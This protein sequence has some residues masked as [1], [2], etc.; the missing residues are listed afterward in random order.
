MP[1]HLQVFNEL[2]QYF[3][4]PIINNVPGVGYG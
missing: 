3:P 1:F 2:A 4:Q